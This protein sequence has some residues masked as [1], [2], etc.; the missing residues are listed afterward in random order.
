MNYDFEKFHYTTDS[1]HNITYINFSK[2]HAAADSVITLHSVKRDDPQINV[3]IFHD[4]RLAGIEILSFDKYLPK[5]VL[6]EMGSRSS[7]KLTLTLLS[8]YIIFDNS[9]TLEPVSQTTLRSS[10]NDLE[11]RCLFSSQGV[12]VG[13]KFSEAVRF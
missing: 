13:I 10:L 7:G 1:E 5:L 6:Q 2:A 8:D 11:A 4:G 12:L 9:D 3:D